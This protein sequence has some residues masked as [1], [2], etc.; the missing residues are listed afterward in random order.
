[1]VFNNI[2]ELGRVVDME[3]NKTITFKSINLED[4]KIEKKI[5]AEDYEIE[6]Y[7]KFEEKLIKTISK[8]KSLEQLKY[9]VEMAKHELE[10]KNPILYKLKMNH[11]ENSIN[12]NEVLISLISVIKKVLTT[13]YLNN[14]K[15]FMDLLCLLF[16]YSNNPKI[17]K[18]YIRTSKKYIPENKQS[19]FLKCFD[20]DGNVL[21]DRIIIIKSI[22]NST[23]DKISLDEFKDA[24]KYP[25]FKFTS[26]FYD[27]KELHMILKARREERLAKSS[28]GHETPE[29]HVIPQY[30]IK[31]F[32]R[33]LKY[34]NQLRE[35]A[36]DYPID[37]IIEDIKKFDDITP[38]QKEDYRNQYD[39]LLYLKSEISS[40]LEKCTPNEKILLKN[41]NN[42]ELYKV[43]LSDEYIDGTIEDKKNLLFSSKEEDEEDEY[44][45]TTDEINHMMI[46]PTDGFLNDQ[47][48]TMTDKVNYDSNQ[49]AKELK[50][51]FDRLKHESFSNLT[52][53]VS[54]AFHFLFDQRKNRSR[55][56][57]YL[58]GERVYRFGPRISKIAFAPI[59]VNAELKNKI[60]EKYGCSDG[61][62]L[63][64][65][66]GCGSC[67][68]EAE[69]DL[70]KRIGLSITEHKNNDYY[71]KIVRL[72][73]D[74][75]NFD[76]ICE[77]IDSS[78][79]QLEDMENYKKSAKSL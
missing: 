25:I 14:P 11:Y 6:D 46:F 8:C 41:M 58:N 69:E 49:I 36:I 79:K 33:F 27:D 48:D 42:N 9:D 55:K 5:I 34:N 22:I 63:L 62:R 61:V 60:V 51:T 2:L 47:L 70:Y 65:V 56:Y 67:K 23:Y 35:N 21:K 24:E 4:G 75:N 74:P 17:I 54:N 57:I 37:M 71:T 18:A 40:I 43:L 64:F 29:L 44:E 45:P 66:M 10:I 20:M 78:N 39:D 77:L 31:R 76:K 38:E 28:F 26:L 1:M 3:L 72:F 15:D 13:D 30:E 73:N 59:S 32:S 12:K 52:N 7:R 16:K 68:T 53:N 19:E 50:I